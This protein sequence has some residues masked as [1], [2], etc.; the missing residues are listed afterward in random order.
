M[1]PQRSVTIVPL[2]VLVAAL[3][4]VSSSLAAPRKCIVLVLSGG[5]AR[6]LAQIGTIKA[7]EEQGL[8]PDAVVGTSMGAIIGGLYAAGYSADSIQH[9]A[10]SLDWGGIY[11]NSAPRKELLM[12]RKE[13]VGNYLFEVRFD[14]SLTMLLPQSISDGQVFY[15]VL[16]PKLA[17][18]QFRSGE[19]FNSLPIPL[20]II[21]TDIL[22]GHSVVFSKGS[23]ITAIRASC[24]FPLVFS[25]VKQDTM[26]LMDGGLLSNIPVESSTREFPNCMV[27]AVDVTSPLWKG[28]DMNNPVRLMDQVVNIGLTRQK[29]AERKLAAA[30]I[31]PDL[32]GFQN[33]DFSRVDTLV[34]RGYAATMEHITEIRALLVSDSGAASAPCRGSGGVFPPFRF[35]GVSN[36][37][38]ASLGR[39]ADSLTVSGAPLCRDELTKAVYRI[40]SDRRNPFVRILAIRRIDSVTTVTL[41]Q[42]VVRGFAVHGNLVTRLSTVQSMLGMKI[43]D[44]LTTKTIDKATESLYASDLFKNVNILPDTNGI[45]D[46][47]LNEKEYWRARIGLRFDEYNLLE[48]YVQPAYENLFGLGIVASLHIQ[49]GLMR[50]KY[51]LELLGNHVFSPAF[52]NMAQVQGYLSREEVVE[53]QEYADSVDSI[54]THVKLE[55]QTLGREGVLALI[56]MQLGKFFMLEGGIRVEKFSVYETSGFHDP[57]GGFEHG[58]QYLMLRLTGDDLDKFPFP[59]KGQKTYITVGVAHDVV[60]GT[61]S[62][63]KIEGG[64][65]PYFT[66]AKIH[67]F[68]PQLQFVWSTDSMPAVEKVY[69]GGAIPEEKYK[70]IGVFDYLSFF[71]LRPR[72]LPGDIAFLLRGNYRVRVRQGLYLLGSLDWGYAWPWQEQWRLDKLVNGGLGTVIK[73][74]LDD[75]PV[76]MGI[77]IAYELPFVGPV[78]FSWGR[79][80]RNKLDPD[81]NILSENLFYFSMGHDF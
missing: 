70:D 10:G 37:V 43:G 41:S 29:E 63:L 59:E 47:A 9:F 11:R 34:G 2:A 14:K 61:E 80:L 40:L 48:G 16:G 35:L 45:V 31:T 5:G 20:R 81:L 23:L 79:L 7:L 58:M 3:V 74:F 68:S 67:T 57:F 56:G 21:S 25:P 73:E 6:G 52:A 42:G 24:G 38:A 65:A 66:F 1:T 18:A 60:T 36:A 22:S 49:Y 13:D 72:T 27:I 39:A 78:C 62:F 76:G 50:E 4:I 15:S 44:T 26:L 51:A 17:S 8:K 77:G 12:S 19:D 75:A 55:E 33:T 54:L 30:L 46:I 32:A 28:Q 64:A 71:G 69:L 53:R